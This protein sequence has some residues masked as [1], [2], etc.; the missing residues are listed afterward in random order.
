MEGI[1]LKTGDKN[2]DDFEMLSNKKEELLK[3]IEALKIQ[4]E[5]ITNSQ[6]DSVIMAQQKIN[7][8]RII[9]IGGEISKLNREKEAID[10]EL[11]ELMEIRKKEVVQ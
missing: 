6:S 1:S 7:Q 10:N 2:L 9:S 5:S 3:K 8:E 11:M 4:L